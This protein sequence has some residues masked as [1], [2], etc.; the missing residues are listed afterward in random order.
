MIDGKVEEI[1]TKPRKLGALVLTRD[2]LRPLARGFNAKPA[3]PGK[4]RC[5]A[6]FHCLL[7]GIAS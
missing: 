5:A 7:F 4:P 2:P 1:I 6:E 3:R